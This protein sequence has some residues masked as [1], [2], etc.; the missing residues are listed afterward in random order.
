MINTLATLALVL[1]TTTGAGHTDT[2]FAVKPGTR[3]EV[4]NFA[5][6]IAV[7]TW[8][9]N[10]IRIE[11]SHS[12]RVFVEIDDTPTRVSVRGRS[13]RGVP[14]QVDY[15]LTV[16]SW[17]GLDLSGVATDIEVS[18]LK[19]EIK[20]ETVRGDINVKGGLNYISLGSV[21]GEV[22][23]TGARGRIELSSVNQ[24]IL[25][26]DLAGDV[27]AETVNGDIDLRSIVAKSLKA[28]TVNGAIL[29]LGSLDDGGVYEMSTHNGDI[30]V[31]VPEKANVS[32]SVATFGGDFGSTFPVTVTQSHKKHFSFTLGTGAAR[33]DLE[34]FQGTI[35]L[36]R[37][38]QV[39]DQAVNKGKDKEYKY[40]YRYHKSDQSDDEEPDH[41]ED[42]EP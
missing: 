11:A 17:I 1:S 33:L 26:L 42:S 16:P 10:A 21:E 34:S 6:A 35:R 39:L 24:G 9:K 19:G 29:Y 27:E 15:D 2:T 12:P 7:K 30:A 41:D 38:A 14:T 32:V 28:S 4:S 3:L 5:G 8:P 40:K 22:A 13:T 37:P 20:A 25:A 23:L 18:G 36:A 31:G